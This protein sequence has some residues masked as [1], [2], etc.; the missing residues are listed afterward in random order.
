VPKVEQLAQVQLEIDSDEA[1]NATA[2]KKLSKS[3]KQQS[4]ALVS[5]T[6]KL[7]LMNSQEEDAVVGGA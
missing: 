1:A 3:G 6:G 7:G 5:K 4:A 2:S